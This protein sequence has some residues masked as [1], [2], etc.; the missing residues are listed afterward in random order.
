MAANLSSVEKGEW[1]G[2]ARGALRTHT[3]LQSCHLR[4][5][6]SSCQHSSHL[7]LFYHEG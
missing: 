7:E 6:P 5:D 1:L 4:I 3:K 2:K